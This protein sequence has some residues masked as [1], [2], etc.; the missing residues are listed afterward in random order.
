MCAVSWSRHHSALTLPEVNRGSPQL[1]GFCWECGKGWDG[2][3]RILPSLSF[4]LSL[5][6][7]VGSKKVSSAWAWE[8]GGYQKTPEVSSP[9]PDGHIS[10][11]ALSR[12]CLLPVGSQSL[13]CTLMPVP[14]SPGQVG[15]QAWVPHCGKEAS[16]FLPF[17][18]GF[19]SPLSP[20][21][22]IGGWERRGRTLK[23]WEH[24]WPQESAR[25]HHGPQAS[26]PSVSA[27]QAHALFW[28]PSVKQVVKV[29]MRP[30]P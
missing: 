15:A 23:D 22:G 26:K 1:P 21:W 17:P 20:P 19:V 13:P 11:C 27:S 29:Q 12:E 6:Q 5:S 30:P 2:E 16:C 9:Y 28:S 3:G 18:A 25:R 14:L 8:R 10:G 4:C 24:L 7:T